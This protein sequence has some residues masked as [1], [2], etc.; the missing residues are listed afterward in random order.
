MEITK[1]TTQAKNPERVNLFVD[2]KFYRGLDK[3]VSLRLGL[4]VGLTLNP[5]LVKQLETQTA[6]N[7]AWEYAL[8]SLQ[9]SAKSTSM[10]KKKLT[11]RFGEVMAQET[12]TKLTTSKILNDTELAENLVSRYMEQG[13]KSRRQIT[14]WF[15]LKGFEKEV[16]DQAVEPID[17]PY[18][19]EVALKLARKKY[20]QLDKD[21]DWFEK[22]DKVSMHLAQKGFAYGVIR[23]IVMEDVLSNAKHLA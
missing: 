11:E 19:K 14:T 15:K 6:D 1:L 16:V 18:E 13:M 23:Q 20:S 22:R 3:I 12:I 5:H 8:K 10:L 7:D 2:G 9:Y 17:E 21:M 4:K